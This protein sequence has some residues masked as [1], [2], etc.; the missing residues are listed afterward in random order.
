M[1]HGVAKLDGASHRGGRR[2]GERRRGPRHGV[3]RRRDPAAV[4][5]ADGRER[6]P[7]TRCLLATADADGSNGSRS[8][9]WKV[10]LQRFADETGL[11]VSVCRFPPGTS[12]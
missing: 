5:G 12:K 11:K 2:L 7:S 10:E 3:V 4:V 6:Y 8:R 1:C 9:L